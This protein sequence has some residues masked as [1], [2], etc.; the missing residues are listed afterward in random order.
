MQGPIQYV[1]ITLYSALV[2]IVVVLVILCFAGGV[3]HVHEVHG[4]DKR[5][6]SLLTNALKP[7][8][9][10]RMSTGNGPS[11]PVPS[12]RS[13]KAAFALWDAMCASLR[14]QP[15]L[16]KPNVKQTPGIHDR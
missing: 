3:I 15:T 5:D 13:E 11:G 7:Q 6:I 9:S 12:S 4:Q 10:F 14:L 1:R 16:L 2:G 8:R